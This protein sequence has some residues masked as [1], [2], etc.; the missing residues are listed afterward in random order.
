MAPTR[1]G[2]IEAIYEPGGDLEMVSA[3]R[4]SHGQWWG[5]TPGVSNQDWR[6]AGSS[7]SEEVWEV[8]LIQ[9]SRRKEM[10]YSRVS[11]SRDKVT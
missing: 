7:G 11:Y 9:S 5:K 3:G 1:V 2:A 4:G 6:Q 8:Y 10:R